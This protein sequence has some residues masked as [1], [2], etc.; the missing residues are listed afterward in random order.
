VGLLLLALPGCTPDDGASAVAGQLTLRQLWMG[1]PF[2]PGDTLTTPGGQRVV[3]Q[4]ANAI[5]SR[6]R[7]ANPAGEESPLEAG[8]FVLDG[9]SPTPL[10]RQYRIPGAQFRRP[11]THLRL[12]IGLDSLTNHQNP[13]NLA[14]DHPLNRPDMHW[15][16]LPAA[17]YMFVKFEARVDTAAPGHTA[18][19]APITIH[20][21]TDAWYTPLQLPLPPGRSE[22]SFGELQLALHWDRLLPAAPLPAALLGTT[23]EDSLRIALNRLFTLE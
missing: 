10:R 9:P 7:L 2:G 18:A 6:I 14:Q 1:Q 4:V 13:A 19:W 12:C 22:P 8:G 23:G 21:V 16:W 11:A 5:V 3:V 15:N 17:G 20:V